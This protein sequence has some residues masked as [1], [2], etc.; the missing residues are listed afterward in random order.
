MR[1]KKGK[2]K[3]IGLMKKVEVLRWN[4]KMKKM[5]R[6]MQQVLMKTL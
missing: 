3:K 2:V 5:R 6:R 4:M 1:S